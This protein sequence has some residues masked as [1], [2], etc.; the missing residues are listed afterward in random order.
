MPVFASRRGRFRSPGVRTEPERI[1]LE[2]AAE[3]E[4]SAR[5]AVRIYV[6]TEDGQH[7]A[8]RV[9]IWSIEQVRD[10]ARRYEIHLMKDLAG[11]DRRR[12]L[13]GF[14]NYRFLIPH[15]AGGAGRAIYNDVDQIYLADPAELFDTAMD[16][17]GFLS[18]SARDTSVMLIDCRRMAKVW[19]A[20]LARR[21]RRKAIERRAQAHWGRL[22]GAWNA[23][24]LEYAAGRSKVLHFTTIHTQPWQPFPE[25]F[26][27]QSNAAG[28]VWH[29]LE[30]SADASGFH[31]FSLAHPSLSFRDAAARRRGG[32][33]D[34][35]LPGEAAGEL[36][37]L[38]AEEQPGTLLDFRL[39]FDPPPPRWKSAAGGHADVVAL[40][41]ERSSASAAGDDERHHD[42]V[43]AVGALEHLDEAD[44]AWV[45]HELFARARRFV[46]A[47]V[48]DQPRPARPR[49]AFWWFARFEAASRFW[50]AVRWRLALG[51]AA[52]V[53]VRDGGRRARPPRVWVLADEKAGHSTQS[54]G[55]AQRLGWPYEEKK[56]RFTALSRISNR[57]RGAS[58]LGLDRCLSAALAPPWPDLV[59]AT[60]KRAA[61]VA[62]WIGEQSRG[63]TRLVQLGRKGGD[64][65]AAF[66]LVVSCAHFRLPSHPRRIE[67]LAPLS[68]ASEE[69]LVEAARRWGAIFAG[70]ARPR[71]GLIVGGSSA[72]HRFDADTA[73]RMAESVREWT[74]AAGGSL[75]VITSPR[76]G[77]EATEALAAALGERVPSSAQPGSA[78]EEGISVHLHRWKKGAPD[79]PYLGFLAVPDVLVVSGES[80]SMLAEAV[81]TGKPVYIYP[82]PERPPKL[83]LRFA[84]A[85]TARAHSRPRKDDKGTV[86]PQQGGEYLCARLIERGLVR[87]PRDLNLLH[88]GL[89]ERGAAFFFGAPLTTEP[90]PPLDEIDAVAERVRALFGNAFGGESEAAQDSKGGHDEM[91]R[92]GRL[93]PLLR[94]L[95]S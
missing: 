1:V 10:P 68:A 49:D 13:T 64:N 28:G 22:D 74:A 47:F 67:T 45:L 36:R 31:V 55:L 85:V 7:R 57:L 6:G 69:R 24:D 23:R 38:L 89:V 30:R 78:G 73:R 88:A 80:E 27:Y 18:V 53:R 59:I 76:T 3:P 86:R 44:V 14:T 56:L 41:L 66:D 15:F 58:L 48:A 63:R 71:V 42:G 39:G 65:A 4:P 43:I 26:V 60:G 94:D 72:T 29:D 92:T 61:P 84:R 32:G 12:W 5:P 17:H 70:A 37:A 19:T 9:L 50:P 21:Q 40:R 83:R 82:L 51:G 91:G 2:A 90:R 79:N 54:L 62:R 35:P 11:F 87:P 8:E 95:R 75:F 16:G 93:I 25:A 52:G 81:A 46:F 33:D 20:E 34:V 77:A